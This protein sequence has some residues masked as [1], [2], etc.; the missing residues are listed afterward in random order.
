MFYDSDILSIICKAY[1][2]FVVE[3]E[4]QIDIERRSYRQRLLKRVSA[5]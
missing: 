3:R 5:S 1:N 2:I 4:R